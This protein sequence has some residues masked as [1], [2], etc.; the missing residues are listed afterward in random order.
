MGVDAHDPHL[1]QVGST[2]YLYGTSYDCGFRLSDPNSPWCGFRTYT[3]T[4]LVHWQDRGPLFDP[5]PWQVRC[6]RGSYGC[7]RVDVVH[8]PDTGRYVLWFNEGFSPGGYQV[9]TAPTPLGPWTVGSPPRLG[10]HAAM[11]GDEA[12]L[13]EGRRAWI[14]YTVIDGTTHDIAFQA[15]DRTWTSTVA[16]STTLGEKLVEAPALFQVGGRFQVA[17]SDPACPYCS[18]TGTALRTAA[19]PLG[20][21]SAPKLLSTT[22]C[23]GQPAFV[24]P[25]TYRGRHLDLYASDLWD[26]GD[27]NEARARLYLA[28][29]TTGPGG[30]RALSCA[31]ADPP[32]P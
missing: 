26:H 6:G 15:L 9:M 29:L 28:P 25:I 19:T 30:T 18:G 23:G 20:P 8:D 21:W 5:G 11:Y 24:A 1:L 10:V 2:Y 27:S 4:D 14:A 32:L 12:L 3:S 13:T 16:P 22:S 7:F 31:G 17:Y